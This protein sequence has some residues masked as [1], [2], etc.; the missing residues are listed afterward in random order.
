M[1]VKFEDLGVPVAIIDLSPSNFDSNTF[2]AW[3]IVEDSPGLSDI[4]ALEFTVDDNVGISIFSDKFD[5][6]NS[7]SKAVGLSSS[8]KLKF[9]L[10]SINL[11]NQVVVMDAVV[12]GDDCCQDD[13]VPDNIELA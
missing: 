5:V 12:T 9:V 1:T 6:V 3:N 10:S 4:R 11:D 2:P 7:D 8:F 13:V